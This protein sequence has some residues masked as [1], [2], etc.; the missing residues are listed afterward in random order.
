LL[1]PG[2]EPRTLN[3]AIP[4]LI[5]V[6]GLVA[7]VRLIV[8]PGCGPSLVRG[9]LLSTGIVGT[10]L[11]VDAAGGLIA[12][13]GGIPGAGALLGF[14]G[15]SLILTT[16]LHWPATKDRMAN[17]SPAQRLRG[18]VAFGIL[19]GAGVFIVALLMPWT[20]RPFPLRLVSLPPNQY[21]IWSTI[22]PAGIVLPTIVA[23]VRLLRTGPHGPT[24]LG[25]A[26]GGGIF[27]TLLFVQV[28]GR[29]LSSA[30]G[31]FPPVYSLTPGP[32]LGLGAGTLI[33]AGALVGSLRRT[34][35]IAP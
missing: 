13:K 16:A 11:I 24:E 4:L 35:G 25:V 8:A 10:A 15:A 26:L 29:V 33:L 2:F 27:G 32:Y 19:V 9:V 3:E 22:L 12:V 1:I 7:S 14:T 6:V 31:P 34:P 28:V 20:N 23:A 17:D 5:P 18:V 21:W 30:I